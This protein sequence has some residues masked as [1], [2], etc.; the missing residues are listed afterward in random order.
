MVSGLI[1]LGPTHQWHVGRQ[2]KKYTK[3]NKREFKS[4]VVN[5]SK[6][7]GAGETEKHHHHTKTISTNTA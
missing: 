3:A 7:V 4:S 1:I 6:G 5:R 2:S